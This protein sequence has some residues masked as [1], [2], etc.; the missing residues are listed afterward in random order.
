METTTLL[1]AI[2]ALLVA[3]RDGTA[4]PT[5]RI[6]ADFGLTAEQ[7]AMLT[8]REPA[9]LQQPPQAAFGQFSNSRIASSMK[10]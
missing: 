1:S 7:I 5:E 9:R 8:G 3:G 4:R 2:L 6:L 10:T